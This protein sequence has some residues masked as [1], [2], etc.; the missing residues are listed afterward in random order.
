MRTA[1]ECIEEAVKV[2]L[3]PMFKK[4]GFKKNGLNFSRR[5]GATGHFFNVQLSQWNSG[6]EGRFYLN[7]GVMFDEICLLRG[8]N[9]PVLPKY[10]DCQFMVRL[11]ALNADLSQLEEVDERTD[12]RGLGARLADL[13]EHS[14][15]LPLNSVSCAR[16]FEST[17]WVQ[18]IPWGFPAVLAYVLG[19]VSEASRLVQKEATRFAD[20]GLTFE[21][22]AENYGLRFDEG[23]PI[24][25]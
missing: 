8:K 17:G 14:F 2:C 15:V 24:A 11:G 7:A 20:R 12:P 21:S 22:V 19:N 1:R 6:S 9:P 23:R 25:N 4:H 13:V 16:E 3:A 18:A 5:L 10:L